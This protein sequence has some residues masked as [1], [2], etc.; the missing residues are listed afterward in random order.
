MLFRT[1]GFV[2]YFYLKRWQKIFYKM[3][4]PRASPL[5]PLQLSRLRRSLFA[6]YSAA[7]ADV[8]AATAALC[9]LYIHG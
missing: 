5:V 2:V 8:V 9:A 3:A 6:L 4:R 1:F 7:T